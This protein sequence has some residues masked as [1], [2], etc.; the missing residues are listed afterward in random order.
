MLQANVLKVCGKALEPEEEEAAEH[1]PAQPSERVAISS[2][3]EKAPQQ[4]PPPQQQTESKA[5]ELS[6]GQEKTG[7]PSSAG[8]GG[9]SGEGQGQ[10]QGQRAEGG[11]GQPSGQQKP[12]R[13]YM[14][15]EIPTGKVERAIQL[16][17]DA[18]EVT[19][20]STAAQL[21][22]SVEASSAH[23]CPCAASA[24]QEGI[25]AK[26]PTSCTHLPASAVGLHSTLG[27]A[28]E[29]CSLPPRCAFAQTTTGS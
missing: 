19:R 16:P 13:R 10:G 24:V 14:I 9:R 29:Q 5:S 1:R 4:Q 2:G 26:C 11:G 7:G 23:R 20:S 12:Q 6:G 22:R 17:A 27:S 8:Q 21:L 25:C 18:Q 3:H 15:K 28:A